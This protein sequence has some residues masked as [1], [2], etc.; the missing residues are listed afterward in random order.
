MA[1]AVSSFTETFS[2]CS[3]AP[4]CSIGGYTL[5]TLTGLYTAAGSIW[6]SVARSSVTAG[7][8]VG[9]PYLHLGCSNRS[10][11]SS[12]A[13]TGCSTGSC[14][15]TLWLL[16]VQ[17]QRMF[18]DAKWPLKCFANFLWLTS[19]ELNT[20]TGYILQAHLLTLANNKKQL[21]KRKPCTEIQRLLLKPPNQFLLFTGVHDGV[22]QSYSLCIMSYSDVC[23]HGLF[24]CRNS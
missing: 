9:L 2:G 19:K 5:Y 10:N 17:L 20:H 23:W 21:E 22:Y 4:L 11:R 18:T 16:S 14:L 8:A 1:Q 7:L 15:N 12:I 13:P 24:T 3:N 6:P